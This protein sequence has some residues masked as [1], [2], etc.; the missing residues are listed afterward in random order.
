LIISLS[1][2]DELG[3]MGPAS[4][5]DVLLPNS[6]NFVLHSLMW[7]QFLLQLC[8]RS[9]RNCLHDDKDDFVIVNLLPSFM[10]KTPS[11]DQYVVL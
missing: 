4:R 7:N 1:V 11:Y 9:F 10:F 5:P 2:F 8:A 6:S 3:R